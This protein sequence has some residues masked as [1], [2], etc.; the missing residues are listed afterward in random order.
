MKTLLVAVDGS[1]PS[2]KGVK[3]AL[4][5]A[6]GV[7]AQLELVYVIPPVLL[8]PSTYAET[9]KKLEE[10]NSAMAKEALEKGKAIVV[11]GGAQCDLITMHGAPAESLADLA[12]AERVWGVVIGA[13]GHNALSRVLLGSTTDRL[14][15]ICAKPVLV[16]R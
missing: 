11:A 5:L 3:T 9:I 4:E 13:K 6:R 15:H 16:V 8:P 1:E 10:A 7:G 2:L 14:M 12:Q